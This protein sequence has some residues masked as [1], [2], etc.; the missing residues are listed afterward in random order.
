[1]HN[2]KIVIFVQI[3]CAVHDIHQRNFLPSPMQM[4]HHH[5]QLS[6]SAYKTLLCPK[7]LSHLY[8]V[9]T[10]Q[11]AFPFSSPDRIFPMNAPCQRQNKSH[12]FPHLPPS[13]DNAAM[14]FVHLHS[15][16]HTQ[17]HSN[18]LSDPKQLW[19]L[20]QQLNILQQFP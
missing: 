1:M 3:H 7:C 9:S 2:K 6:I 20:L 5:L 10:P 8:V 16:G 18:Y 11:F 12:V 15:A 19:F 4:S 17:H 14:S 13:S